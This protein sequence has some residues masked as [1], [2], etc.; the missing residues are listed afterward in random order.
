MELDSDDGYD[1][2]RPDNLGI[3]L[4]CDVGQFEMVRFSMSW[5]LGI[6]DDVRTLVEMM[7]MM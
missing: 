5:L 2:G 6:V 3:S 4:G 7:A 1:D